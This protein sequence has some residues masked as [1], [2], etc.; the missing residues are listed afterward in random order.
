[1]ITSL[2]NRAMPLIRYK[3]GDLGILAPPGP[4]NRLYPGQ[5]LQEVLG[6]ITDLF[7]TREGTPVPGYYFIML[8]FFKTWIRQYQVVQK[9]YEHFVFKI[10]PS[11]EPPPQEDLDEIVR[12]TRHLF[13]EGCKV[14]IQFV[15]EIQPSASGKFRYTI[16]EIPLDQIP[17]Y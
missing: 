14:E 6:R 3:I 7:Q 16:S 12:R 11:G 5:V 8:L 13:G 1:L 10:I 17:S 15:D 9:D 4:C 2:T